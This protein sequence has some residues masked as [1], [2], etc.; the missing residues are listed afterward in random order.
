MFMTHVH[1]HTLVCVCIQ[2]RGG[3]GYQ[4]TLQVSSPWKP[5]ATRKLSLTAMVL[6]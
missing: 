4:L 1:V 5:P 6:I 3:G 2:E